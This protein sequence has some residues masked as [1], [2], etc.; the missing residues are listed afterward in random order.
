[1]IRPNADLTIGACSFEG[2]VRARMNSKNTSTLALT[3]SREAR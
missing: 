1:M 3:E 2:D